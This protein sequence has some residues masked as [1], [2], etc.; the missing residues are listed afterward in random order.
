[1]EHIGR[2]IRLLREARGLSQDQ[3]SFYLDISRVQLSYYEN[4][5]RKEVPS[6]SLLT[7]LSDLFCVELKTLLEKDFDMAKINSSF[8]FRSSEMSD[9]DLRAVTGFHEL[10]KNYVKMKKMTDADQSNT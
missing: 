4:Y 2:N 5:S 8:A 6:V 1:M 3:V 9:T 10:V 7:K